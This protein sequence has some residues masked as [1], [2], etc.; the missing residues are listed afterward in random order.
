MR[1]TQLPLAGRNRGARRVIE[2]SRYGNATP[3]VVAAEYQRA[4]WSQKVYKAETIS[5]TFAWLG[6]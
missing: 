3:G 2:V 1:L 4:G 5:R 6:E